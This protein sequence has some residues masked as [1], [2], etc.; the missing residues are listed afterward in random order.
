[1]T[2]TNE[3]MIDHLA[4]FN[5]DWTYEEL[6][7]FMNELDDL[8]INTPEQF[9]E[10]FEWNTDSYKPEEEF[11]EHFVTEVYCTSIPDIVQGCIDWQAVWDSSLRYDYNTI[12]LNNDTYFFRNF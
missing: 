12:T 4:E 10:S 3:A 1:M 11:A 2:T 8:G 5:D 6:V 7:E 9:D